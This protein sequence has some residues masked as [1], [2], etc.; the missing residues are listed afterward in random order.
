MVKKFEKHTVVE[1]VHEFLKY[2]ATKHYIIENFMHS[3]KDTP[4]DYNALVTMTFDTVIKLIDNKQLYVAKVFTST[5][6]PKIK[7]KVNVVSKEYNNTFSL[8]DIY[9]KHRE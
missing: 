4:V 3:T 6:V 9:R 7:A 5:S 8:N 1:S 2:K